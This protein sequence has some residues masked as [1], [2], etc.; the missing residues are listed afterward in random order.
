MHPNTTRLALALLAA[1]G[2]GDALAAQPAHPAIAR[3]QDL[4][5]THAIALRASANDRFIARDVIVD[6]DGTEHVRMDRT[7]HGLPVIGGDVIVHSQFGRF[8]SASLTQRAPLRLSTLARG[9]AQDAIVV[10]GLQFGTG[11]TVLPR[12]EK[13]VYARTATPQLAWQVRLENDDADMTYIVADLDG[14]ILDQWSNRETAAVAGQANTLYSGNVALT[15]NSVAVGGFELRDPT[16]GNAY[17][18]NG[19]TGRTSGQVYKDADNTWG[20]FATSDLATIAADAQYGTAMTWDYYKLVHG[21]NGI[22]NN[23]VGAYNR[24]HYGLRYGNAYWNDTCFCMTYGD[25]DG[26]NIGPLVSIDIAGHEMSHG[27]TARTAQL[28]YSGESGGLNEATS[29]IFGTMVEFYANN[30][31]D[32]PDYMIGEKIYVGNVNGNANQKALRRMYNPA[33][34]GKSQNC[35]STA[36][37]TVDVHYSS[38]VANHFFYLLAEG[39][40]AKTY[41]GVDHT[42]PTCDGSTIVGIGRAKAEKIWYRALTTQMTSSTNYAGARVATINAATALY[43][44]T[45]VEVATV[46]AAWTAVGVN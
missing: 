20:N 1:I 8:Q 42:S 29:D 7:Y 30:S 44:A 27:V 2:A 31:L 13:V 21:R 46:K 4:I 17:T 15:T 9:S 16:R 24:V 43:G 22:A 36:T 32:T 41:N 33:L 25:G 6:R 18:I 26:V 11:F 45:S 19:A 10:A 34:D 38:G 5:P 35:W 28:I 14:R 23:G 3:A 12:S 39:S 37:A 40:G